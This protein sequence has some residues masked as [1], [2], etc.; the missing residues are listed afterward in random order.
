MI[1]LQQS[2]E[3]LRKFEVIDM[4]IRKDILP[5]CI[6]NFIRLLNFSCSI[7]F[8]NFNL[9]LDL[10]KVSKNLETLYINELE[11]YLIDNDDDDDDNNYYYYNDVLSSDFLCSLG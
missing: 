6:K 5:Y 2:N 7:N 1:V 9:L 10:L 3:N 11:D 4:D 8:E